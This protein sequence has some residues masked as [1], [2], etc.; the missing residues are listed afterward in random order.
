MKRGVFNKGYV[1]VGNGHELY[2]E[3]YGNPNGI[4]IVFVHG[5]PGAGFSKRHRQFF[6]KNQ[7]KVLFFDQRGA[8]KSRPFASI[9]NN[10]TSKL[11][12]DMRRLIKHFFGKKKVYLMGGSWGS[13]LSLVY[14][15]KHPETVKGM[16]L[17]GIYLSTKEENKHYSGGGVGMF[18]PDVWEDA[19]K[20]VPKKYHKDIVKYYY[21]QN[22]SK[23]KKTRNKYAYAWTFYELSIAKLEYDKKKCRKMMKKET[24]LWKA[25][26][27]LETHYIAHNC[28]LPN[29]FIMK[30]IKKIK[31]MPVSIIN[32]R[33][34]MIC[35]PAF[36]YQLHK[37]LPKSKLFLTIA[38]HM[39]SEPI[40]KTI[41]KKEVRRICK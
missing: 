20:I 3:M 31:H 36:A 10:T 28:F 2:Y 33:Y 4:P 39:R 11:V 26:S 38:G 29:N 9:K 19:T 12:S 41:L 32:G 13:T 34:D 30:N 17:R 14:S 21:K 40:N 15:I 25:M 22:I 24:K 37:A 1:G 16:V 35:P 8:G 27:P 18:F 7:H 5:G 23:N 6:N